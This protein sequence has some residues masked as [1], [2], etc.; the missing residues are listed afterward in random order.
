MAKLK[1]LIKLEGTIDDLTFYKGADGYFVRAKG[2]V[3]KKRIMNDPA[4]ARTREN[5]MEFGR[6]AGSGKLLRTAFGSMVFRAK[7]SKLTSRRVKVMGQLKNP[8]TVSDRGARNVADGLNNSLAF[9]ILEGFDFNN[10][11]AFSTIVNSIV[12]VDIVTGKI[13]IAGYNPTEQM[14]YPEGAT[15]FSLQSGFLRIDFSTGAY[16]LTK[17]IEESYPL[18]NSFITPVLT[19]ESVPSLTGTGMHV[20]LIEF[21]QEINGLQ[22]MLNNG[23]YN[24]LN[25]VKV[26]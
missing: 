15:H 22:Y 23:A 12:S 4:F 7:D 19:P 14:R 9:P 18:V 25:I 17:S 13:S 10:R 26:S 6:I 11:A 24:V 1:S 5:G 3:S 16:E 21:F 20:I 2:G 8:D